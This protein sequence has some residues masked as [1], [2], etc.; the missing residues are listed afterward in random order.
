MII[1][2]GGTMTHN[3]SLTAAVHCHPESWCSPFHSCFFS[4]FETL[5]SFFSRALPHACSSLQNT[6]HP[7]CTVLL[8]SSSLVPYTEEGLSEKLLS[9][10]MHLLIPCMFSTR[11]SCSKH[12]NTL[13][14]NFLKLKMALSNI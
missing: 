8:L 5:N 14:N 7:P 11:C 3:F 4:C 13:L 9:E 6:P 2:M 10:L 1:K 12:I